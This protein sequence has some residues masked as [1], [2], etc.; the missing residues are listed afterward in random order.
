MKR[1]MRFV[2][3]QSRLVIYLILAITLLFAGLIP[4]L[5]FD[6][7]MEK[8]VPEDDPVIEELL[9][10]A[11]DFGAQ[12]FFMVTIRAPD[13]FN[14]QT[15]EKIEKMAAELEVVPDVKSILTPLNAQLIESDLLGISISPAA[16]GIP[17]RQ[18]ELNQ[19]RERIL[20]SPYRGK[21]VSPDGRAAALLLEL[22]AV[23]TIAEREVNLIAS[24]VEAIVNK[25]SGPEEIYIVGD[26]YITYYA[27]K[28]MK[29]DIVLLL[30]LMLLMLII[31][32]YWS[33]HSWQGVILPLATVGI[34]VI[35]TTGFMALLEIPISI[36]TIMMP[37]ILLAIGSADGIHLI[38]KYYEELARGRSKRLA[39]EETM[40]EM[41]GPVIMTSLTTGAGF[42][43]L[44]TS[45]LTPIK[46]FGLLTAFGVMVAM[47]FSLLFIPAAL[48]LQRKPAHF[49][50]ET[51]EHKQGLVKILSGLGRFIA[52][53]ARLTALVSL[54]IFIL[55]LS[56][57]F[58]LETEGNMINYFDRNSSIIKGIK[59]VEEEFG[60]TLQIGIVF[61]TGR[62]DGVKEP[63]VLK[64]MVETQEYLN[65]LPQVSNASS[66]A[67]LI[68]DLNQKLNMGGAEF[69]RIPDQRQTVAQE[70]LLYTMQGGSELESLVSYDFS[71]ALLT[72]RIENTASTNI[73]GMITKIESYIEHK[74]AQQGDLTSRVIGTPKVIYRIME[75][76]VS[77]QI[78]SFLTSII[79]V[80]VIVSLLM[81]SLLS[82]LIAVIP[83]LFTVGINFGIMG[84]GGIPLDAVT[85]MIASIAIGIGV[86]YSIHYLSRYRREIRSGKSQQEAI[87]ST[88]YS[89]GR[90]IFF[91]ALTLVLGFIILVF[92][93]FRAI[94]IF[95][96]LIA[97]TMLTSSLA[98]LTI[99]P[100]VVSLL[101]RKVVLTNYFDWEM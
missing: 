65:S 53:H 83:L 77:T 35:W 4:R 50:R 25:Y 40:K 93:Q 88:A 74:V 38:N 44:L 101:P 90:G 84:Y 30:P 62:P 45:F 5:D 54:L 8:M 41:Y 6:A 59:I 33:F 57:I 24:Q 17:R 96:L 43:A 70:L 42:S 37:V 20:A 87:I 61:D 81:G 19:F 9:Q 79:A 16:E 80:A 78:S 39:L 89:A 47:F 7:R 21:L 64:L 63:A 15:L 48:N 67:D 26:L 46:E 73:K 2:L 75:R 14:Q 94:D 97:M 56:G 31:V 71:K 11:E 12:D 99:V 22:K 92:S 52:R 13:I 1:I 98:S 82:G 76:F 68:R 100:A 32:L 18:Q 3:E 66:L 51:R 85:T 23:E 95:G 86:D 72:A 28:V 34:S 60:G 55:I 58:R 69:Y 10:A 27:E 91:N 29:E 36:V 49:H